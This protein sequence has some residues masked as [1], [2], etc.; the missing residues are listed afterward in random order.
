MKQ[1]LAGLNDQRIQAALAGGLG[2]GLSWLFI[3]PIVAPQLR[4]VTSLG[5]LLRVDVGFGALA[6]VCIGAALGIAEGVLLKSS[7]RARRGALIGA[8]VGILGGAVGCVLAELVYQPLKL[9]CFVGRAVGWGVF[10]ALLGSAEGITRR[11]LAGLRSATLGGLVGGAIGGFAFD[12]VAMVVMPLFQ[13]DA[14]C[15]GVALIILG[16]CIGLWIALVEQALAPAL[17][18]I[19][20][21]QFEGRVFILD[22]PELTLGSDERADVT[23]FGDPCVQRRHARLRFEGGGYTLH[24]EPAAQ[25]SVNKQP[26]SRQSLHPEDEILVG[27]TRL[28]YRAQGERAPLRHLTTRLG[29]RVQ[30]PELAPARVSFPSPIGSG[31]EAGMSIKPRLQPVQDSPGGPMTPE[32]LC[33][34]RLNTVQRYT[35]SC[36]APTTIGR[37]P[38]NVIVLDEPIV[39]AHHAEIQYENG[40]Y[41]LYD[42]S[43]RNGT[44]VN[45]RCITGPNLIKAGWRLKVGN[46]EF[47]VVG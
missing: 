21:G 13:S 29:P 44:F 27:Q 33:L 3:E 36:Y 10:G 25:V 14:L 26:I 47:A 30:P 1:S 6:G 23:I 35:L 16:A 42:L 39:S 45:E 18:K 32:P 20:S 28:I 24:A 34:V 19:V 22:K 2:G 5:Q 40:R 31:A 8:L 9:L 46:V 11:S 43:S 41:V 15:R 7:Y 4:T 12:A 17:L 37:A 38:D